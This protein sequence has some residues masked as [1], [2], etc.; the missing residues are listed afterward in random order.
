MGREIGEPGGAR[1]GDAIN[2]QP[3]TRQ[4]LGMPD[5]LPATR[6]NVAAHAWRLAYGEKEVIA[7]AIG[8]PGTDR[9]TDLVVGTVEAAE[10]VVMEKL[11]EGVD[12]ERTRA[13]LAVE[14]GG[15]VDDFLADHATP[16]DPSGQEA[17][18]REFGIV[19]PTGPHAR[20]MLFELSGDI[21]GAVADGMM[22][23]YRPASSPD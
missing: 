13:E 6:G 9:S 1:T 20:R 11:A 21:A 23:A 14:V 17:M 19:N 18:C 10:E 4:A 2:L 5:W 7:A 16:A 8:H 12:P 15:W 3:L 22:A